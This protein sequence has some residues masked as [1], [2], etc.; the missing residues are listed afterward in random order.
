MSLSAYLR[1][2][3]WPTTVKDAVDVASKTVIAAL[4]A[5][6]GWVFHAYEE[7]K[8][9]V[10]KQRAAAEAQLQRELAADRERRADARATYTFFVTGLPDSFASE[11][12]LAKLKIMIAYCNDPANAREAIVA[13]AC[14]HLPAEPITPRQQVEAQSQAK[15]DPG[16]YINSNLAQKA[17]VAAAAAEAAEA[18]KSEAKWYAVVGTLPLSDPSAAAALAASLGRRLAEADITQPI[19]LYETKISRSFALTLGG[20]QSQAQATALAARVRASGVVRDAFSQPDRDWTPAK[21]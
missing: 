2:L 11:G 10:A 16:A 21:P 7:Q 12:A 14:K 19:V 6:A 8:L 18:P 20:P 9:E 17:N 5:V 4:L 13:A 1:S 15:A 3:T